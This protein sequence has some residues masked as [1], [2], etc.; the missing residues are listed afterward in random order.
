MLGCRRICQNDGQP[1]ENDCQVY[2]PNVHATTSIN[3]TPTAHNQRWFNGQNYKL[4]FVKEI[5][6][7]LINE[8]MRAK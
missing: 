7:K 5:I 8:N 1:N 3:V 6:N 4:E 2:T